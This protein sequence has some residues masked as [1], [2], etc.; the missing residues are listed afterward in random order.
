MTFL[1]GDLIVSTCEYIVNPCNCIGVSGGGLSLQIIN[2]YPEIEKEYIRACKDG[3]IDIGK[4]KLI[5]ANDGR[6][7][8]FVPTKFHFIESSTLEMVGKG[9]VKLRRLIKT[10]FLINENKSIAIPCL[11][12]GLGGCNPVTIK[13]MMKFYLEGLE[14][15]DCYAP[16]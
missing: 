10:G 8:V 16:K 9:L 3:E 6:G 1:T 5:Y 12:A 7:I 13:W 4:I 14:K 15:V 2:K 11:G